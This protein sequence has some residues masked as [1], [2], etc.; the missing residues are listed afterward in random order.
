[1]EEIL[2][3]PFQQ[4]NRFPAISQGGLD[5]WLEQAVYFLVGRQ[6]CGW[7]PGPSA[8][9]TKLCLQ[10][11]VVASFLAAWV[12]RLFD[13]IALSVAAVYPLKNCTGKPQ[14]RER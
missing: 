5:S 11:R 8:F 6:S 2:P 1:M 12:S 14:S 13:F 10:A 7:R 9:R 4:S 3:N